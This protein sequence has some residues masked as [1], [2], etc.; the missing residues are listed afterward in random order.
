[1][2]VLVLHDRYHEQGPGGE[3]HVVEREQALLQR[4]AIATRL[5][6]WP[7]A[8]PRASQVRRA[9]VLATAT[10]SRGTR[11][12]VT[13]A[14]AEFGPDVVHVHNFWPAMTVSAHLACRRAGLPVV[15]TLHNYRL[16]CPNEILLREGRVC[17]LCVP[18][19]IPWPA[20]RYRCER[21]SVLRSAGKAL[22]FGAYRLLDTWRRAVTLFIAPSEATR[23]R[24]VA[25][26]FDP[27]QL[28]VSPQFA[29]DPG[30]ALPSRDHFFFAGRLS[31][32]K[33][34]DLLLDVWPRLADVPLVIAGTGALEPR[35]REMA[36]R[37]PRLRALGTVSADE[38]QQLMRRA[39]ATL[40][41]SRW[42]E[43][44]P[45]VIAES[46]AA[47]TPV[48]AA[49]TGSRA[50]SVVDGETGWHFPSGD[51]DALARLVRWAA[52]NPERC[53]AMGAAARARY[54]ALHTEEAAATRL[55]AIYDRAI[56]LERATSRPRDRAG[57]TRGRG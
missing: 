49:S 12:R 1:M 13:Q 7:R 11:R 52:D 43:A 41:P 14:V 36:T 54:D 32:E 6:E 57:D 37:L 27:A 53:R 25:A 16:V 8:D 38:T 45:L 48:I 42:E 2:R 47:S 30:P 22:T 55:L 10:Y 24:F 5:V 39:I 17:D 34:V 44:A 9:R 31:P 4:R 56:A 18:R 23:A 19:R 29:P 51:G 15:Q 33:G 20:I 40:L 21:D 46:Y 26:G 35:A 28:V 50:E 3:A